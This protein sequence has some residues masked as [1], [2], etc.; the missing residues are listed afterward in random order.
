MAGGAPVSMVTAHRI[1]LRARRVFSGCS[2]M[3]HLIYF[4]EKESLP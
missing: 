3:W 1:L 4:M 2:T